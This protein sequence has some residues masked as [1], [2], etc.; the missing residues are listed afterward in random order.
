MQDSGLR[1]ACCICSVKAA[2]LVT[3]SNIFE[4]IFGA[5][6]K[7]KQNSLKMFLKHLVVN[8]DKFKIL[9]LILL[10]YLLNFG[11]TSKCSVQY[12]CTKGVLCSFYV[13]TLQKIMPQYPNIV[14]VF[15]KQI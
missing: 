2:C 14:Y 7:S 6:L 3:T 9:Y 10:Q 8:Y 13:V 5:N 4:F 1:Q 12:K 15:E 11:L